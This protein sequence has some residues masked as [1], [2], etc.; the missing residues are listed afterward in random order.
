[1]AEPFSDGSPSPRLALL[2]LTL[3][4][5]G[6]ASMVYY[7]QL[8]F[9]PRVLAIRQFEGLGSGYSFGNDFYPVWLTARASAQGS[10]NIYGPDMT[11][12]IQ[13]GLFGRP[14]DARNPSDPS[15]DYRQFAYPAFTELLLWPAAVLE[16]PHLRLL[17]AVLLPAITAASIWIWLKA[18]SWQLHPIYFIALI[19]L[20]LSTYQLLEAFFAEQPGLFVGFF[21]AAAALAIR[22]KRLMLAGA[23]VSLT[24]IKPQMTALAIVYLLLW[25]ISDRQRARLWQGFLAVTLT[26]M[27]TSLCIWPHW[28][29]Q[30]ANIL[31]G[32]HRYAMP[33][34][35]TILLGSSAPKYLSLVLIAVVLS[36]AATLAWRNRR[37]SEDSPAFWFT[38]TLLLAITCVT[39]LPGQA[40]YDH[41][42][43]IPG[44]LLVFRNSRR[45]LQA[46]QVP[47]A[48]LVAGALV[49][50]WPWISAFV[51]LILRPWLSP[52]TFYATPVFALPI[53]TAASLPVAVLALLGWTW[54]I[55]PERPAAA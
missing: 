18:L 3:S 25:S 4:L 30:W 40:I 36:A 42:I 50:A 35:V 20:S 6:A 47:R 23:L 37:A 19:M 49:L 27:I 9:M 32:Y 55:S 53:R 41:V 1:M 17:L 28:V 44:I 21:L 15:V 46:G 14:L 45:L 2:A 43:L 13:T 29:Q 48:L 16:F 22:Q 38:L 39:L 33:P 12:A 26:L 52:A 5:V 31:L 24:L 10:R 51:L 7:H 11:R 54:R 8:L 34:L